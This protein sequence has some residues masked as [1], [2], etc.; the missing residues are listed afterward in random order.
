[1]E[2]K[3]KRG[4]V[5]SIASFLVITIGFLI[6]HQT[7]IVSSQ[8]SSSKLLN[9]LPNLGVELLSFWNFD[10]L[11]NV[12]DSKGTRDGTNHGAMQVDSCIND[13]AFQFDG[14]DD[15]IIIKDSD[16]IPYKDSFTI[17][18]FVNFSK[19]QNS[20]I[21]GRY[22]EDYDSTGL[23]L[24][25]F[26]D[27]GLNAV[28]IYDS[29]D[30]E[31]LGQCTFETTCTNG[32]FNFIDEPT[33]PFSI[34]DKGN[35]C[36]ESSINLCKKMDN[37]DE[38]DYF[39]VQNDDGTTVFSVDINGEMCYTNNLYKN[40]YMNENMYAL[41]ITNG[42]SIYF[43]G[44]KISSYLSLEDEQHNLI[45][46]GAYGLHNDNIWHHVVSVYNTQAGQHLLYVDGILEETNT[47]P[48]E[49]LDYTTSDFVIGAAIKGGC[50]NDYTLKNFKG[51]IDEVA[52]WNR[53]LGSGEITDMYNFYLDNWYCEC[54][55]GQLNDGVVDLPKEECD[56]GNLDDF[57]CGKVEPICIDKDFINITTDNCNSKACLCEYN[58]EV[59]YCG[60]NYTC[61][62]NECIPND[63]IL[64]ECE[65]HSDCEE[66]D[67]VCYKP[68]EGING[69]CIDEISEG[70]DV[71]DIIIIPYDW[72]GDKVKEGF[73]VTLDKGISI[74]NNVPVELDYSLWDEILGVDLK[75]SGQE[76]VSFVELTKPTSTET[77]IVVDGEFAGEV[78]SIE[79]L[80]KRI[81][82]VKDA[83]GNVLMADKITIDIGVETIT[84]EYGNLG[85]YYSSEKMIVLYDNDNTVKVVNEVSQIPANIDYNIVDNF[86]NGS[87]KI[88]SKKNAIVQ[89][90]LFPARTSKITYNNQ[91]IEYVTDERK[92]PYLDNFY[93]LTDSE[94]AMC[95]LSRPDI[96][97]IGG[98][99]VNDGDSPCWDVS[100]K[101]CCGNE[102]GETWETTLSSHEF[103]EDV[104][105]K[106]YCKN[107][108]WKNRGAMTR[109]NLGIH[110][111]GED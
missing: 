44:Y 18:A 11:G 56:V 30:V 81:T 3:T 106:G 68:I 70:L 34:D 82:I 76:F 28:K 53:G 35:I 55:D 24:V 79:F 45:S 86:G 101:K 83:S 110:E 38:N 8:A 29:G 80:P 49:N 95:M 7:Y 52:V 108:E 59:V 66:G 60:D 36:V 111:Q 78:V 37:C 42:I 62:T 39:A 102:K 100:S 14:I 88:V 20:I 69:T 96:S 94:S 85:T 33:I 40:R 92:I 98:T 47:I 5:F 31:F 72:L 1:M 107:G 93:D 12:E 67:E 23:V 25:T 97:G 104:V 87:L 105:V 9:E 73:L 2:M 74:N 57:P 21:A 51:Q 43:E 4:E 103:L 17:S 64:Q 91:V 15:Y 89:T 10:T 63:E 19:E 48:G 46:D 32:L 65:I 16:G 26:Q 27:G 13:W 109:Y 75:S 84:I 99:C 61:V 6:I 77:G 90:V 41:S 58:S 50:D 22:I 71:D 54:G